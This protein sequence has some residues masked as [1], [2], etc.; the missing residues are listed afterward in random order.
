MTEAARKVFEKHPRPWYRMMATP[1]PLL[2]IVDANGKHVE[3]MEV[4]D[5]VNTIEEE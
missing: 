2:F 1:Y 3:P 4:L 5:V